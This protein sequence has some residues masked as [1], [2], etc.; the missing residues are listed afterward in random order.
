MA[1]DRPSFE[2]TPDQER[3]ALEYARRWV[4]RDLHG[5]GANAAPLAIDFTA[6]AR[7]CDLDDDC[8]RVWLREGGLA[9]AGWWG[10]HVLELVATIKDQIWYA[11][12]VRGMDE[13]PQDDKGRARYLEM[14]LKRFDSQYRDSKHQV[15]TIG[16]DPETE[17]LRALIRDDPELRRRLDES[18]REGG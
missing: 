17:R 3:Y 16:A 8:W 5:K 12:Y 14:M 4:D 13:D 6:A 10:D 2:P 18:M 15:E 11:V 7:A 1:S 9:F